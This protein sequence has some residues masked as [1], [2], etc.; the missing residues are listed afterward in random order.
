MVGRISLGPDAFHAY[1]FRR[2][3]KVSGHMENGRPYVK[4]RFTPALFKQ[5]IDEAAKREISF[6]QMVLHL[7]EASIDGIE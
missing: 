3:P 7:C 2:G 4:V 6:N 5:I 1:R